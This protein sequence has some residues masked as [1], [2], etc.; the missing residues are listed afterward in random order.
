VF[1]L[2]IFS[3]EVKKLDAKYLPDS[4]IL[5][6]VTATDNGKILEVKDGVWTMVSVEESSI[7][8]Y[9]KNYINSI[10]GTN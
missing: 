6:A 7:A 10:L 9:I 2:S 5:P 3:E 1:G 8:T 4:R